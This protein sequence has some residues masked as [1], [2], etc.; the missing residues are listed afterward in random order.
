M[1]VVLRSKVRDQ[2][3]VLQISANSVCC[4]LDTAGPGKPW[5]P[6]QNM[7]LFDHRPHLITKLIHN[8]QEP[9]YFGCLLRKEKTA[10]C[11]VFCCQDQLQV[12]GYLTLRLNR[13]AS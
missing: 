9:S 13:K 6:L 7:V 5:D 10:A 1:Y 12:R 4:V 3:V 8:S 2:P 11:Y